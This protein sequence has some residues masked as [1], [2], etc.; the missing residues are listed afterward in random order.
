[1][2][3]L[4]NP[5]IYKIEIT[6]SDDKSNSYE[7]EEIK[8]LSLYKDKTE[9][10]SIRILWGGE[11]LR[12]KGLID[13]NFIEKYKGLITFFPVYVPRIEKILK[14]LLENFQDIPIIPFFEDKFFLN[15]PVEEKYYGINSFRIGGMKIRKRG[16]HGIF[17]E[18]VSEKF[19]S[20]KKIISIVL[21]KKTTICGIKN[22]KPQLIS[23]GFTPL[24]GIMGKTSSGDLDPGI[25]FYMMKELGY[26][27]FEVDNILKKKSGFYGL[28]GY[29]RDINEIYKNFYKKDEKVNF[30]FK[31]YTKQIIK[32]IGE[33]I[34]VLDG[35]DAIVFSG[36]YVKE[37]ISFI[38]EIIS[39]ISFIGIKL[40]KI[41]KFSDNIGI[42]SIEKIP[43]LLNFYTDKEIIFYQTEK[44]L[45][46]KALKNFV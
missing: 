27:I 40:G 37:M 45:K 17:H 2:I 28:T 24:E 41:S 1:M 19:S 35:V 5:S 3:L 18:F 4:L 8:K 20:Y 25:V 21:D 11:F 38:Y 43:V 9:A 22:R 23:I 30:T 42:I 10:I 39:E 44:V 36:E 15:L 29:N 12:N 34:S 32:Y 26:S 31:I 6:G 16:F 7:I 46:N 14:Y 13:N 33:A